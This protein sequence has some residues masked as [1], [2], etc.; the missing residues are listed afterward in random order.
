MSVNRPNYQNLLD[1]KNHLTVASH[2]HNTIDSLENQAQDAFSVERTPPQFFMQRMGQ[3][4]IFSY[5]RGRY[6]L[7]NYTNE[8]NLAFI[9]KP[10]RF[11]TDFEQQESFVILPSKK[12]KTAIQVPTFFRIFGNPKKF[13]V[14]PEQSESIS[15]LHKH[16]FKNNLIETINDI[17]IKAE[18][19]FFSNKPLLKKKRNLEVEYLVIKA[20][21]KPE[22]ATEVILESNPRTLMDRQIRSESKFELS[23]NMNKVK[24]FAPDKTHIRSD[25][26]VHLP[27]KVKTSFKVI[28]VANTSKVE[29][30]NDKKK[31]PYDQLFIDDQPDLFIEQSPAKRYVSVGMESMSFQGNLRSIYC[32]EVDPNEEIFIPNVY[33]MLLIQN[34]WDSL[35]MNSFRIC[36][37]P[38]GY[39]S[40]KN[41]LK[42]SD[43]K[44]NINENLEKKDSTEILLDK[45]GKKEE[46]KKEDKKEGSE[47]VKKQEA[48]KADEGN[49]EGKKKKSKFSLKNSIFMKKNS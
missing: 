2:A 27:R 41:L 47:Q 38:L 37:R 45:E 11:E 6:N 22:N 8:E 30:I 9:A 28:E 3:L 32:L 49:K 39:V 40:N 13:S 48:S 10:K 35:E 12:K 26:N 31:G 15:F 23:Y 43:N 33:D 5:G 17:K 36:L 19:K 34:F 44:E 21:F 29:L 46:E 25:S 14:K 4:Q 20:P 1:N 18:G 16:G 24:A 7:K 42:Q